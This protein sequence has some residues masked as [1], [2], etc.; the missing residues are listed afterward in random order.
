[1]KRIIWITVLAFA[2]GLF[3]A[4][5]GLS[6]GKEMGSQQQTGM[7]ATQGSGMT[8]QLN[9]QQVKEMQKLLNERGFEAGPVDG[10]IGPKTTKAVREYQE[11]RGLVATGNPDEETLK[12]LA[13]DIQTQQLFGIA[14]TFGEQQG[15]MS[16]SSESG[17]GKK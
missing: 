17:S 4:G 2:A 12:E 16:P 13:P 3:M 9:H 15:H 11:S 1:M 6:A 14:P 7:K 5:Q 10:I 8:H